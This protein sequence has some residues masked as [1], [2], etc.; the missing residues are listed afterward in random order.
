MASR[1]P[2]VTSE[3]D[4]GRVVLIGRVRARIEDWRC[5]PSMFHVHDIKHYDDLNPQRSI[6]VCTLRLPD[7][8]HVEA[9]TLV[10]LVNRSPQRSFTLSVITG[11][12]SNDRST[13]VEVVA[14]ISA[15]GGG[16]GA[17]AIVA[18]HEECHAPSSR[19]RPFISPSK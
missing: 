18:G 7:G 9:I 13:A 12:V 5:P 1:C 4:A 19:Q 10:I 17:Y 16:C 8:G 2:V 6:V 14:R 11:L 15:E 3:Y